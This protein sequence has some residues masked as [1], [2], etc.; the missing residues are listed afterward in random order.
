M[1]TID[2]IQA[3]ARSHR[4]F[5]RSAATVLSLLSDGAVPRTG[6]IHTDLFAALKMVR[7]GNL[8]AGKVKG[9]P[10]SSPWEVTMARIAALYDKAQPQPR[11]TISKEMHAN[12]V[13]ALMHHE[14]GVQ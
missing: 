11:L 6:H 14:G 3:F 2:S 7:K 13:L 10:D 8:P 1:S 4:D 9:S 5:V 12:I